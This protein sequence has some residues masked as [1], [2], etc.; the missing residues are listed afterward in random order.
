[1]DNSKLTA[2]EMPT[3]GLFRVTDPKSGLTGTYNP[4]GSHRGGFDFT[5]DG[6]SLPSGLI[7]ESGGSGSSGQKRG[8]RVTG[9]KPKKRMDRAKRTKE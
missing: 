4:D 3:N 6:S 5:W 2:E 9:K 8:G 7:P 1:M